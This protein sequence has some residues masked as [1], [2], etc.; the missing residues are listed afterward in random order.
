MAKLNNEQLAEIRQRAEAATAGPWRA[1]GLYGVKNSEDITMPLRPSDAEFISSA[2]IDIPVL[3]D[4]IA[5]LQSVIEG[6]VGAI[7]ELNVNYLGYCSIRIDD[8]TAI[9]NKLTEAIANERN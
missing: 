1:E 4:M 9:R 7:D 6:T 2:R 8:I 3:L 5:E